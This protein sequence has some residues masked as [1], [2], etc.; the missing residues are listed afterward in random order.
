MGGAHS[1]R[2]RHQ[3]LA[4]DRTAKKGNI[5]RGEGGLASHTTGCFMLSYKGDRI[6]VVNADAAELKLMTAIV[7]RHC[8]ILKEG[9]DRHLTFSYKVKVGGKHTMIQMVAD[10]L[11]S[12]YQQGWEPMTPMDLGLRK[13]Q[14]QSGP[15]TTICFKRKEGNTA[16]QEDFGSTYSMLS[17][18]GASTD[19]DNSCL[20]LEIFQSN[21][22]GFYSTSNTVL[23]DVISAIQR[24][25][26]PG[27]R[28]V[29]MGVA[30]VIAD[31]TTNMPPVLPIHPSFR[32][33][34]YIQLCGDPWAG[35]QEDPVSTENLQ[36]AM[37]ACLTREGYKLSMD[38]NMDSTSRVYFFIRD[39]NEQKGDVRIPHMVGEIRH[40]HSR[41]TRKHSFMRK[42][43]ITKKK[44]ISSSFREERS[45]G[46]VMTYKPV[47]ST[48]AWWQ[49]TSTDVSTDH[50]EDE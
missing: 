47:T 16:S 28:G 9:W 11:L 46:G 10:T 24:E 19:G 4:K 22:L 1:H 17:R 35:R 14:I 12:L 2:A 5:A 23:H 33:E 8:I 29:S 31:Y 40:P 50:E 7:K 26:A 27:I 39:S 6:K 42:K 3:G 41:P 30:S 25:W 18:M 38:I 34:K 45:T 37:N 20:C 32:D 49:Q 36:M 21:Y 43:S 13:E 15:Q 44:S 48:A